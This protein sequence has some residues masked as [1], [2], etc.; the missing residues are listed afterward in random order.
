MTPSHIHTANTFLSSF[1]WIRMCII[2]IATKHELLNIFS[3]YTHTHAARSNDYC[4]HSLFWAFA[5]RWVQRPIVWMVTKPNQTNI[6]SHVHCPHCVT[7]IQHSI[8]QHSTM[9]IEMRLTI[10]T[11]LEVYVWVCVCMC[12][13]VRLR[14]RSTLF[15]YKIYKHAYMHKRTH[16]VHTQRKKA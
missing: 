5:I 4:F 6:K 1:F 2:V 3:V 12:T 15:I 10:D 13:Q 9:C 7:Y 14:A 16:F 8:A 11:H